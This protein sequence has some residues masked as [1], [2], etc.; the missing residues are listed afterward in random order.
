ME[1]LLK[2][3]EARNFI[4]GTFI[5]S[6]APT[7]EVIS[8]LDGRTISTIPLSGATDLDNAVEYAMA[9]YND[10]S[11]TPIKERVQILF[12]YRN[13][14]NK[15]RDELTELVHI[16]N[17]KIFSEAEAEVDKAIELTEFA[18]S[19]PQI[20]PG[21]FLEVS[22]GVECRIERIPLGVVASITP[23]NFP[24]MVP[25]WTIP[26][27]IGLGN[28]MI[29]K[30]SEKVPLTAAR[31]ALILKEAGLPDGVFNVINGSQEIVEA[32]CDHPSIKAVSFVGSTRVAK[33]V[34]KRAT[35]NLKRCLALGG[36]K[37]H[38]IVLPDAQTEMTAS[39]IA[40]SMT[41]C[42]GQRCMAASAMVAVG[43]IDHII[44]K[45]VEEAK[46]IIPGKNLGAVISK[47]AKERIEN[48]VT[49][50]E[51]EGAKVLLDG[52]N[53][54]VSGYENGFYVGP[55]ILDFVIPD[56]AIAKEEV[57]GPV[58]AIMRTDSLEKAME[59][60]K[61]SIYGNAAS[62]FT[63]N[64]RAAKFVADNASAGMIGVNIGVPVPREPFSFGGMNESKFGSSD[65]TGKSSIE[66]WTQIRKTTT[67]W[68]PESRINWM[69]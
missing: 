42:A 7:M 54:K 29:L 6:D 27:V 53:V 67:K 8:P 24:N 64:G 39:N 20:V 22:K 16:E 48:Y 57:F 9:A 58:L 35:S 14:L 15:Y 19:L 56:M 65:I 61:S 47:E 38:L 1:T 62:V 46:K 33:I 10:W 63:Q 51:K 45:L 50:A 55:T 25:N 60:E 36:A 12:I 11:S 13:L 52:R 23:F 21:E 59:I 37:N 44:N 2:F 4:N 32:I 41:G 5:D 66:F 49:Q 17:G 26:I 3:K 68:S 43:E 34:Y 40:A 30:P 28:C 31:L 18:C 69:S